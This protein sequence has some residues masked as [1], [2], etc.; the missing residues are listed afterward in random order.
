MTAELEHVHAQEAIELAAGDVVLLDVR[1]QYEVDAVRIPGA[2]HLALSTMRSGPVDLDEDATYLVICASGV[3]S[4]TVATALTEAGYSAINVL[5][6]IAAWEQAGGTV[7][8]P[9]PQTPLN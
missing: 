9:A 3:R 7:V 5:G 1:E 8:R 6:G 4:E 2:T